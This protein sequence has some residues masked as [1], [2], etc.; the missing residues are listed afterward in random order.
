MDRPPGFSQE[1]SELLRPTETGNNVVGCGRT[2]HDF[3]S[4]AIIA[5]VCNL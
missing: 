3:V 5:T 1:I 4:V 2:L